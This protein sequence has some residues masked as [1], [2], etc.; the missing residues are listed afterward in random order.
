MAEGKIDKLYPDDGNI[1]NVEQPEELELYIKKKDLQ[2]LL[3]QKLVDKIDQQY[4]FQKKG[5]T[6]NIK[7]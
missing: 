1:M 2:N 3:L 5:N 6:D 4:D 7:I